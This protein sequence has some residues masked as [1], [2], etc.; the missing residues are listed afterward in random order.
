MLAQLDAGSFVLR[1]ARRALATATVATRESKN[2]VD[3]LVKDDRRITASKLWLQ[4]FL[5]EVGCR[6]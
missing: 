2:K 3:E 4:T 1:A 6:K 5:R